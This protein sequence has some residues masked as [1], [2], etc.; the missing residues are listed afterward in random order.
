[1]TA[2]RQCVPSTTQQP[3]IENVLMVAVE[4]G[5]DADTMEKL[6]TLQLRVMEKNA[7][8]AFNRAFQDFQAECPPVSKNRTAK[9]PAKSGG[10]SWGYEFADLNHIAA[11]VKPHLKRHGFSFTFDTDGQGAFRC[12]LHHVEGHSRTATVTLPAYRAAQINDLQSEGVRNSY[13]RRYA[14]LSVLGITT[15]DEDADGAMPQ[16]EP[17]RKPQRAPVSKDELTAMWNHWKSQ[18]EQGEPAAFRGMLSQWTEIPVD[19]VSTPAA[20]DR[21]ALELCQRNLGMTSETGFS[22]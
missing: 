15:G 16:Q 3:S 9:I 22:V 1:M 11:V 5:V 10:G 12:H 4:R 17:P 7:E 18:N 2:D 14:L 19:K 13:G 21:P 20:W 6:V 8:M